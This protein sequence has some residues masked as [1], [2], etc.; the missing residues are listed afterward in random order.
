MED[1]YSLPIGM[2]KI[3]MLISSDSPFQDGIYIK[4]ATTRVS[5]NHVV[6]ANVLQMSTVGKS[7]TR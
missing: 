7:G 2:Q 6:Q 3:S 1:K 4:Q 5:S